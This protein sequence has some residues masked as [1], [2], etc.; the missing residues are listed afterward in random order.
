VSTP[1]EID[2]LASTLGDA[3]DAAL[4]EVGT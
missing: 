3:I 1:A 2:T 4:A